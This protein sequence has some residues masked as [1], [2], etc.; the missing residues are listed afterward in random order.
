M[1]GIDSIK[2]AVDPLAYKENNADMPDVKQVLS[3]AGAA[4]A[5]AVATAKA[6]GSEEDVAAAVE[7]ALQSASA[8][9]S[10]VYTFEKMRKFIKGFASGG[11]PDY[12][13]L[14]IANEN[15]PEMVG[16]MGSRNVVANDSQ[17]TTGIA[18]AV[19]SVMSRYFNGRSE[20]SDVYVFIDGEEISNRTARRESAET[21]RRGGR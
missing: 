7:A 21:V 12:G 20:R 18:N 17:I 1:S 15:G 10:R 16:R 4:M 19:E 2:A 9:A 13:E 14:F 3:S 5:T 6:G 8:S 11:F